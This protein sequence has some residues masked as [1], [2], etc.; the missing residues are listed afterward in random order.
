MNMV[1]HYLLPFTQ[2]IFMEGLP[3]AGSVFTVRIQD[4]KKNGQDPGPGGRCTR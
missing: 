2:Q 4:V 3:N 1:M